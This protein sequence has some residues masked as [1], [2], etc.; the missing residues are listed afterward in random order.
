MIDPYSI[1]DLTR[2][3]YAVLLHSLGQCCKFLLRNPSV[4]LV[5]FTGVV[6]MFFPFEVFCYLY[7]EVVLDAADIDRIYNMC[8]ESTSCLWIRRT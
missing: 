8:W 7:V 1:I 6:Y 2:A 5:F 4:E 3:I